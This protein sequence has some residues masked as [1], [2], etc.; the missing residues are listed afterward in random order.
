MTGGDDSVAAWRARPSGIYW[1]QSTSFS[2]FVLHMR[3]EN[4][5]SEIIGNGQVCQLFVNIITGT[6]T[7]RSADWKVTTF[8]NWKCD[9]VS[10]SS[11]AL[12]QE[13]NKSVRYAKVGAVV[14]VGVY[15]QVQSSQWE[16][17]VSGLPIPAFESYFHATADDTANKQVKIKVSSDG[18]LSCRYMGNASGTSTIDCMFTYLANG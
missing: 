5:S 1:Y 16:E 4:L 6:A 18:T 12:I 9:S 10:R 13:T 15:I 17:I 3:R 7:A 14:E 2:G 11:K 8:S